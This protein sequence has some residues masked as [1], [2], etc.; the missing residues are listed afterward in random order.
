MKVLEYMEREG[1][2]QLVVCHEP[3][4]GLKA[5]IAIHDT[6]LGPACGGVRVWPHATEDEA[7]LDVLRLAKAMTHKSAVAGLPLGGGK[8]LIMAD[9]HR[10]KSEALLRAF[11][12]YV[13]TLGGRYVT[14]ED[15]GMSPRDLEHI[16][17]ETRHMVGLPV[18]MGG[19][20]DTSIMTGLGL[21]LAM[22][23]CAK[24]TWGTDGLEGR[25]VAMQG[26]GNVATRTAEHLLKGGAK[27]VVADVYEGAVERARGMGA[28]VV[29]PEAI[30]DVECDVFSP[31]ALGGSLNPDTVPRLKCSFVAGGANNQLREERD[32]EALLRRGILYAPDFVVNAGGIVNVACEIDGVYQPDRA[33]KLTERIY[34][35]TERV[36][37]IA[38]QEDIATN[39]AA[40]RLAERRLNEVRGLKRVYR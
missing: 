28:S 22:K 26:F 10:D 13:D 2:E 30:F 33:R 1:H 18:S 35:T 14:T 11:G 9:A 6:T 5:F 12:R 7:L 27:L 16:A 25:V 37:G 23:A 32:G 4:V 15:V 17:Q 29:E 36:I 19:S 31:C 8:A 21:Y 24:A 39:E 40:N 20:G 38:R 34:E 3:S